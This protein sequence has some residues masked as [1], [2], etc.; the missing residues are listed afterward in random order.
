MVVIKYLTLSAV[1]ENLSQF[2]QSQKGAYLIPHIGWSQW[3]QHCGR[4]LHWT[5]DLWEGPILID[6]LG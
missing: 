6:D 3:K 2:F 5:L 4:D 1:P